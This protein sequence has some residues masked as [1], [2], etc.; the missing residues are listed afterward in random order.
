MRGRRRYAA[1]LAAAL[2]VLAGAAVPAVARPVIDEPPSGPA[3]SSGPRQ[4]VLPTG[5]TVTIADGNRILFQPGKGRAGTRYATE[6]VAG[7]LFVIPADRLRSV[8]SGN[9]ARDRFDV[10]RLAGLTGSLPAERRP[11]A[12]SEET[13]TLTVRYLDTAGR[14][15]PEYL[16]R[17]RG[18]DDG[19][20]LDLY[21][22]DGTVEVKLPKGRYVLDA[23]LRTDL[24]TKPKDHLLAAP[25]LDLTR[26]T[27][28]DLDAR[29]SRPMDVTVENP[30]VRPVQAQAGFTRL[31]GA[32]PISSG[33]GAD[34]PAA[35]YSAQVGPALPAAEL[36]SQTL[37]RW[38][39]PGPARDFRNSP[40]T[41]G[42]MDTRRGSV[43]TGFRRHARNSELAALRAQHN[44]QVEGRTAVAGYSVALPE[45]PWAIGYLLPYD[46]PSSSTDYLEPGPDW[47]AEVDELNPDGTDFVTQQVWLTSRTFAAGRRYSETWN[48]AVFGPSL[49]SRYEVERDGE[50]LAA[51]VSPY[52]DQAGHGSWSATGTASTR[53]YRNDELVAEG[54][55]AGELP[56]GITVPPEKARYRLETVA[57]RPGWS[58]FSTHTEASWTFDSA[59]TT[60]RTPLPLWAIRFQP[61]VDER[62][63]AASGPVT[64][65]PFTA[66]AQPEAVVGT[67]TL[68]KVAIS[69]DDGKTWHPARVVRTGGGRFVATTST[70][71]N[72][73][74]IS[75]RATASDSHGNSVELTII[76]T[77]A[78]R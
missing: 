28:V 33:L 55:K 36:V 6:T 26:D 23:W 40:V 19:S 1:S 8:A 48:A 76:R 70:P 78:L 56:R 68:P 5:D 32:F 39:V 22:A 11:A 47:F 20:Y 2:A 53:L 59:A 13:Y 12:A 51:Y 34:D 50:Y 17:I 63:R 67:L 73:A 57:D 54:N 71:G 41:Y 35:L 49:S 46:Q 72:P 38:A 14:P 52:S 64:V 62:N 45:Q 18:V 7:H 37:S 44:A 69:G 58:E 31:G 43:F 61:R 25:G 27:T 74:Y 77:Y 30:A 10:T 75:L 66:R 21:D 42:L 24:D 16:S 65:L 15:T 60:E 9:L 29:L 4:A 3:G